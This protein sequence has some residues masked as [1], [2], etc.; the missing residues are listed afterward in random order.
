MLNPSSSSR[1]D[2]FP[3]NVVHQPF[4]VFRSQRFNFLSN[5]ARFQD[6]VERLEDQA[7]QADSRIAQILT[8]LDTQ[9][10]LLRAT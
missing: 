1:K 6:L 5:K 9:A 3:S 4:S 10:D 7:E 2:L 8:R